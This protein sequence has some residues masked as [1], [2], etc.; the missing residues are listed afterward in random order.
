MVQRGDFVSEKRVIA[1]FFTLILLLGGLIVKLAWLSRPDGT[2]SQAAQLHGSYTLKLGT[3]RGTIYDSSMTPLVNASDV[4]YAAVLPGKNSAQQLAALS[5]AVSDLTQLEKKLA[6]RLPFLMQ[7]ASSDISATGVRVLR[8]K[9]RY[10]SKPV[11]PQVIGYLNDGNGA[12]GIEKAFDKELKTYSQTVTVSFPMDASGRSLTGLGSEVS[13][14]G[15]G[16]TGGVELTLDSGI[17]QA[18][19]EAAQKYIK[20]GAIVVMNPKNGDILASVSVPEFSQNNL[21]SAVSASGSPMTNKVFGNYD[22]GS[23]FKVVIASAALE[24]GISPNFTYND[25]TGSIN[26]AGRL[27]HSDNPAGDGLLNMS[28]A[29][30]KSN[31]PYFINLGQKTGA[32]KILAMAK[33][34]GF[35]QATTFAPGYATSAGNLPTAQ[36]ISLPGE[37][38]N[39]SM[40]QGSLLVTPVQVARMMSA[41]AN[42]GLLPTPRLVVRT[43]DADLKT[44]KSFDSG[45]SVRVFSENTDEL[46]K[47]FLIRTVDEGTGTAAKPSVGGAGGK[48]GTA[49]TGVTQSNGKVDRAWFAGFY[50]AQN[51]QYVIV[52][53]KEK[54]SSG[55]LDSGPAFR[56]IANYLATRLGLAGSGTASSR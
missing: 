6:E 46:L 27:F 54:G 37:L 55:G 15:K 44:V 53:V 8:V 56:Y 24:S 47:S 49:Q 5:P 19:E 10:G 18:A 31:N 28:A 21:A 38:A 3:S 48:T 36:D 4:Y 1:L 34:L 50:P 20:S 22:L 11:A 33:S 29:F 42:G 43:L 26:V 51:P 13:A 2:I 39:L 41:A 25:S 35:G 45:P 9:Q 32:A 12:A 7:V 16:D 14:D 30:A 52:A 23:V 17:Q 40:G